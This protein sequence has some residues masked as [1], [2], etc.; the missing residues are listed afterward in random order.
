MLNPALWDYLQTGKET[1]ALRYTCRN[2]DLWYIQEKRLPAPFLC[3][4]MGRGSRKNSKAFYFIRNYSEVVATNSY[5]MLYSKTKLEKLIFKDSTLLDR[6]WNILKSINSENIE[7][8]GRVYG[9]AFK[10]IEPGELGRV[11]CPEFEALLQ[12]LIIKQNL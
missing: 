7:A 3:P 1:T 12:K 4:C 6:I 5:I 9:G 2:R 8:E 10:K 11:I